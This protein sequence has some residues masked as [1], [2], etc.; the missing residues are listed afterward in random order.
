MAIRRD[1]SG[2]QMTT[3]R[4]GKSATI[5]PTR[6]VDTL[7]QYEGMYLFDPTFGASWENCEGEVR[8]LMER[9]G[10]EILLCRKWDER[11]LAYPV[12]GRKRGV[13]ALTYFKA[14]PEKIVP[15]ERD[16]QLSENVLRLLVLRADDATPES[17]ERW[18]AYGSD[19]RH[20]GDDKPAAGPPET[21]KTVEPLASGPASS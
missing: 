1:C 21:K 5:E 19:E 6:R 13:Y 16:A 14:S 18:F 20:V 12:K 3:G 8:R 17:M 7:N 4:N 15:L 11:R 10:A 2:K 9:A